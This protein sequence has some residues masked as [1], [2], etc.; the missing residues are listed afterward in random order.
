[1]E[2]ENPPLTFE[3]TNWEGKTAVRKVRP[4]E[5]WYG[6]TKW[7]PKK[8]WL[9]KAIDVEK[10]AERDFALKDIIKFIEE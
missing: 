6:K 7:H 1:M 8:G 4:I 5:I 10:G 3:Y 9:L 2:K